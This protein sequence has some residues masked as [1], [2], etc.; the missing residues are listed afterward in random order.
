[1][2]KTK[3]SRRIHCSFP[4]KILSLLNQLYPKSRV[5]L[6]S[7]FSEDIMLN[8][9]CPTNGNVPPK[10]HNT[11]PSNITAIMVI[12]TNVSEPTMVSCCSPEP[13]HI[14]EDCWLWCELAPGYDTDTNKALGEANHCLGL[15]NGPYDTVAIRP[16][17]SSQVQAVS[18]KA[19]FISTIV[20]GWF[21]NL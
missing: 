4:Q 5:T 21:L 9:S 11:I 15:P 16:K 8:N 3:C 7:L 17:S 20:V 1:M 19:L 18:P 13:V 14:I 10:I 6:F 12:G 2:N